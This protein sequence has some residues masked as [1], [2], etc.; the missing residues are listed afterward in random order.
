LNFKGVQTF[1]K[2]LINS[3]K[4]CLHINFKN[5]NLDWL[6]CIEEFGVPLQVVTRL[7]LIYK[8]GFKFELEFKPRY[9]VDYIIEVL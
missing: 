4:F 8:E 1:R 9:I 7:G 6:T 2:N 5:K 3:V